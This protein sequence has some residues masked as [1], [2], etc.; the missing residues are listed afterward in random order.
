MEMLSQLCLNMSMNLPLKHKVSSCF[1]ISNDYWKKLLSIPDNLDFINDESE[2]D[3]FRNVK[4]QFTSYQQYFILL[5]ESLMF[6]PFKT[7]QAIDF[8]T[9]EIYIQVFFCILPLG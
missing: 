8:W 6:A 5:Y 7:T 4:P 9:N 1:M 3:F 2:I